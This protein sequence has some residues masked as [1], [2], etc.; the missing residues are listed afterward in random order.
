MD[1]PTLS[2]L[3]CIVE[4]ELAIIREKYPVTFDFRDWLD[5]LTLVQDLEQWHIR[6]IQME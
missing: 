6:V 3:I 4:I 2:T 1:I 5:R